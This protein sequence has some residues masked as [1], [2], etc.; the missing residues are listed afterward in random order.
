M[1]YSTAAILEEGPWRYKEEGPV[2]NPIADAADQ[3][4]YIALTCPN[5]KDALGTPPSST[6]S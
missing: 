4:P 6:K 5:V 1:A 2:R 3:R